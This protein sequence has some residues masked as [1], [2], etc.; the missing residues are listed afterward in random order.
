VKLR[1]LYGWRVG[2]SPV[3]TDLNVPPGFAFLNGSLPEA[4]LLPDAVALPEA[5]LEPA[6]LVPDGVL[7]ELLLEPQPTSTTPAAPA[8]TAAAPPRNRRRLR[9]KLQ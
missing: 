3:V 9:C 5:V 7:L 2:G 1:F 8:P 6:G 4:V